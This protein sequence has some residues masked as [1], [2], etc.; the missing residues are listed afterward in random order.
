LL[1]PTAKWYSK[2]DGT[3]KTGWSQ[4]L[5]IS[6]TLQF[7]STVTTSV[8]GS[9]VF[10]VFNGCSQNGEIGYGSSA[11]GMIDWVEIGFSGE[12]STIFDF[13]VP[14]PGSILALATG[15]IGFIGLRRRF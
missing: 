8:P 11:R 4:V 7:D 3:I 5:A 9:N 6:A 2:I 14:E 13:V 1:S 15:L 10:N 12:E